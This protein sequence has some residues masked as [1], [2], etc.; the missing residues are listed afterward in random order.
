MHFINGGLPLEEKSTARDRERERNRVRER[1][2][3][4]ERERENK[5]K[6]TNFP[7]GRPRYF[8]ISNELRN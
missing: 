4:T 7:L 3:E 8:R 1:E 6:S 5:R 2:G